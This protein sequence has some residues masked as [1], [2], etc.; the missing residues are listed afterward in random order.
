[1][2]FRGC[3]GVHNRLARSYHSGDTGDI[4]SLIDHLQ[5]KFNK[6]PVA[7]IGYSLGG[8]ALLKYLGESTRRG[9]VNAAV[10]ISVP[11]VLAAGARK[12]DSGFSKIYQ[13]YLI[14]R[15]QKKIADKFIS[16]ESPIDTGQLT[17]LNNFFRFDDKITAPLH[18][19]EGAD[20]YY[21]RS[22][23]RQYLKS[24][25]V[26]TLLIQARDDPFMTEDVIPHEE[27]LSGHV[28]MELSNNG[29]H[30]GFVS[31]KLPWHPVYWLER[32]ITDFL[33]TIFN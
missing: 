27:E 32:R 6:A 25:D 2:Y 3:S 20:D 19:F 16:G 10:A 9:K 29:G 26:P 23:S 8:N 7:T 21:N 18:G 15:L 17:Q 13:W 12:L 31:G 11:Y 28:Q 14:R 4:A 30:V 33:K 1:M 24:I 22:S 5:I